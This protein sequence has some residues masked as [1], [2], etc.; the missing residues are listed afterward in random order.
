MAII[1]KTNHRGTLYSAFYVALLLLY[2][3]VTVWWSGGST[4]TPTPLQPQPL[5]SAGENFQISPER[6]TFVDSVDPFSQSS[7][8]CMLKGNDT[9]VSRCVV[10]S[11]GRG[12]LKYVVYC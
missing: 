4:S 9:I 5:S 7:T 6:Y 12:S 1:V 11:F 10:L 8:S 3:S 2:V